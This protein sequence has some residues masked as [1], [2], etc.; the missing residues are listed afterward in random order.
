MGKEVYAGQRVEP[1]MQLLMVADLSGIWVEAA[2][3]EFE[4]PWLNVG[5]L[6]VLTLPHDP[7]LRRE[8][9]VSY[10]YPALDPATRT[11][12]VRFDFPNPELTLKPGM[13]ADVELHI[14]AGE[15]IVVPSDAVMDTG[16]RQ[17]VFVEEAPGRFRPRRVRVAA[18]NGGEALIAEGLHESELVVVHANFLIDSESR[19]RAALAGAGATA[20]DGAG[21]SGHPHRGDGP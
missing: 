8:G 4:A 15:G 13:F 6:A 12:P 11:L 21:A 1:G 17:I 2:F 18:R 10:V 5:Q 20:R 9:R 19:L 14:D 16:E 7:A 3:Y